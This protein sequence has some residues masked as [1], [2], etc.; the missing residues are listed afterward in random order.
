[1]GE[2]G[3]RGGADWEG[4]MSERVT[5]GSGEVLAMKGAGRSESLLGGGYRTLG[6]ARGLLP[7][8]G[9]GDGKNVKEV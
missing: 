7:C 1:M 3:Q 6:G 9:K 4:D 8:R 5:A 2:V